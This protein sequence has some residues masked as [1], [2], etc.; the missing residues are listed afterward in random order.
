LAFMLRYLAKWNKTGLD[1]LEAMA[2]AMRNLKSAQNQQDVDMC[3][4]VENLYAK[5]EESSL[6]LVDTGFFTEMDRFMDMPRPF[7][8]LAA[9]RRMRV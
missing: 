5:I 1:E 2:L 9:M 3:A 7:E 8:V 4:E 6:N